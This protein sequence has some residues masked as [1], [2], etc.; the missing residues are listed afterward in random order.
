MKLELTLLIGIATSLLNDFFIWVDGILL[1]TNAIA[2]LGTTLHLIN[3]TLLFE[4]VLL[5]H[6]S[7]WRL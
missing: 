5:K 6:W 7:G 2:F 1:F 4:R 3:I